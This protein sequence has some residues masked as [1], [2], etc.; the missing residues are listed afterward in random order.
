MAERS[1]QMNPLERMLERVA[2]S[3]PGGWFFVNLGNR[4]DPTLIRI[5]RGST[6]LVRG[7]GFAI[8]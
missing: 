6:E 2:A 4:I 8:T 5:S 3:R 7:R 1:R